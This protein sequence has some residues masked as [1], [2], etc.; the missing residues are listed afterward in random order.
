MSH[1]HLST[2]PRSAHSIEQ[3]ETM[4]WQ[5]ILETLKLA[6]RVIG[7]HIEPLAWQLSPED[8]A[9]GGVLRPHFLI[10][11]PPVRPHFLITPP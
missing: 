6:D 1:M 9:R 5:Y 11:P 2:H 10:T 4:P 8:L 3:I 7:V